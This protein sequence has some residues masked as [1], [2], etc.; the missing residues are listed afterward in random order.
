[1]A[2]LTED[3]REALT[4]KYVVGLSSAE[5]GAALGRNAEAVDSLLQR[6]RASFA[7]EWNA[8]SSEEVNL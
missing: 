4:L 1:M 7:R 5:V 8:L 6:G 2:K 3:Q